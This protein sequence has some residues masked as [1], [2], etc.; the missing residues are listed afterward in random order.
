M[1]D[2]GSLRVR[3]VKENLAPVLNVAAPGTRL[4]VHHSLL[5]D[6]PSM[7]PHSIQNKVAFLARLCP[8]L[9]DLAPLS[10]L[11]T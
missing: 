5:L 1:S 3:E 8:G 7:A 10:L 2:D 9:H 4:L 6:N 11:Y